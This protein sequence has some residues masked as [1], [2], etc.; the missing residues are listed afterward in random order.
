MPTHQRLNSLSCSSSETPGNRLA[1][2]SS[3]ATS[4]FGKRQDALPTSSQQKALHSIETISHPKMNSADAPK[5]AEADYK[6][7]VANEVTMKTKHVD[8]R[9]RTLISNGDYLNPARTSRRLET[10]NATED[11]LPVATGLLVPVAKLNRPAFSALQQDF[12]TKQLPKELPCLPHTPNGVTIEQLSP[13]A[14][15]SNLEL[16]QLHMLHR[17]SFATKLQWESSAEK[18]YKGRFDELASNHESMTT[19]ERNLQEQVNA[20]AVIAWGNGTDHVSVGLKIRK[21]SRI[22]NE[23]VEVSDPSGQY[24]C[25]IK[26]FEHWY[27]YA[28]RTRQL[29]ATRDGYHPHIDR[30]LEGMGDGWK[31]E[32]DTLTSKFLTYQE[33]LIFLGDASPKSDL[34]RCIDAVL[35][36]LTNML[37]ELD[38]IQAIESQLLCEEESWLNDSLGRIAAELSSG[39]SVRAN[40]QRRR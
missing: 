37:E 2:R 18:Y 4:L 16:L 32:A 35:G 5:A 14:L 7:E 6:H 30:A 20:S 38:L 22:L 8:S 33:E 17:S 26:S 23:V 27:S 9:R 31:A 21:L 12:G 39:M 24:S 10:E 40:S 3:G 15:V 34:I 29:R 36:S 1:A 19:R 13:E 28:S 11:V 25:L